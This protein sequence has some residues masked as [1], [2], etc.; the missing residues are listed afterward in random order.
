M[1]NSKKKLLCLLSSLALLV[2]GLECSL[3]RVYG[4]VVPET[5]EG[6]FLYKT[7]NN[8]D[9]TVSYI[10]I[11]TDYQLQDV[12][13]TE[14]NED[15]AK[16]S[17]S[18]Q[19]TYS[20]YGTGNN[21]MSA[22]DI[23]TALT[24]NLNDKGYVDWTDVKDDVASDIVKDL[25]DDSSALSYAFA[26]SGLPDDDSYVVTAVDNNGLSGFSQYVNYWVCDASGLSDW[27]V[28]CVNC[29]GWSNVYGMDIY[30]NYTQDKATFALYN[31]NHS[32]YQWSYQNRAAQLMQDIWSNG[33]VAYKDYH[34]IYFQ[35]LS[36]SLIC[37]GL[38]VFDATRMDTGSVSSAKDILDALAGG[39]IQ[40]VLGYSNYEKI[41]GMEET[42]IN[43][44][45]IDTPVTNIVLD[46]NTLTVSLKDNGGHVGYYCDYLVY[47]SND[48][49]YRIYR[50][51]FFP[52]D[53]EWSNGVLSLRAN[54]LESKL[55]FTS[56]SLDGT[57]D[58]T[59]ILGMGFYTY[60]TA[61]GGYA[62]LAPTRT[63]G[64][65]DIEKISSYTYYT[66]KYPFAH[67]DKSKYYL[68]WG[69]DME[70]VP[71]IVYIVDGSSISEPSTSTTTYNWYS[72]TNNID[73]D[74]MVVS[75]VNNG[76]TTNIYNT[77]NV[78]NEYIDNSI[79]NINNTNL[80]ESDINAILA[81]YA[82][83][84]AE[85]NADVD[86]D[87]DVDVDVDA[88]LDVDIDNYFDKWNGWFSGATS[89][90]GSVPSA[91]G[92][93]FSWLP[94]ELSTFITL[95]IA[96]ALIGSVVRALLGR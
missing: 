1:K 23:G 71:C 65:G 34:T 2:T 3:V 31:S 89:F 5:P 30:N 56:C 96:T 29:L 11:P 62:E 59:L 74:Y 13:F 58:D 75:E 88:D 19:M 85:L 63:A 79:T 24:T 14:S 36:Q 72:E 55:P 66:F 12:Y 84:D 37:S 7:E 57:T 68:D 82:D 48:G 69:G 80:T 50:H 38:V 27:Y 87:V 33:N 95:S 77:Y 25:F 46:D 8:D 51:Y 42:P 81:A 28:S 91:L 78:T 26:Y 53:S 76:V 61:D 70:N 35:T 83:T 15:I 21:D 86:T 40:D 47:N 39:N 16:F 20:L 49:G 64:L 18:P 4:S 45:C 41:H 73:S 44:P 54:S 90:L 32:P 22:D 10:Y 67:N 93:L 94:D 6:Y 9:G 17:L 43:D 52:D 92:L 60:Y